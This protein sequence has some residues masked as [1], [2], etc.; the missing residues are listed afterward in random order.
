MA[1]LASELGIV[2]KIKWALDLPIST[3]EWDDVVAA[4]KAGH[5]QIFWNEDAA[6]ITEICV[7][8]R[9]RFLNIFMAAGSLKGVFRLQPKVADFARENGLTTVQGIAR[10]E[11]APVLKKRGWI[12]LAETWHLPQEHWDNG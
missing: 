12:K 5:M 2:Q 8:P 11:W 6:V 9:R 7:S 3:H 1:N 4:L 10:P